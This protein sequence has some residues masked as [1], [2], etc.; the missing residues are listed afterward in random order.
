MGTGQGGCG[1]DAEGGP[2]GGTERGGEW[3]GQDGDGD[4]LN[5]WEDNLENIT[6][7]MD[8]NAPLAYAL[9][10]E[11]RHPISS[12]LGDTGSQLDR[13]RERERVQMINMI[14]NHLSDWTI[15]DHSNVKKWEN[16]FPGM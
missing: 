16:I 7:G 5:Q 4:W 12:T 15:K 1:R 6:S 14:T 10:L 2:G 9:G 8:P 3:Y 11:H 13:E